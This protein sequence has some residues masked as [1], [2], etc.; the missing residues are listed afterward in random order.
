[1]VVRKE[2]MHV[3]RRGMI[4]RKAGIVVETRLRGT[5]A[6]VNT[7]ACVYCV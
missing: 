2:G 6:Y 3:D 4:R 1:M 5:N 7:S